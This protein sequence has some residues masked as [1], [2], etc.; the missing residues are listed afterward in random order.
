MSTNDAY[1]QR[2][3]PAREDMIVTK[4]GAHFHGR[5][6]ACAIGRGGIN[7]KKTEGDGVSPRGFWRITN[8]RFRPD[9]E[10]RPTTNYIKFTP[11]LP[12]DIWSDDIT[13]PC[14]NHGLKAY[15]HPFS[16]E[17]LRRADRLYDVILISDWN[18]PD[19]IASK[20]SAIFVHKWRKPRHPTEGCIAFAAPD[21]KWIIAHW[22][23][24][25]RILVR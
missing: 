1:P 17:R 10:T 23:P 24:R 25:S 8:G 14:Y 11:V 13:D 21:L 5:R 2:N 22:S 16:H 18:F 4:W 19:A 12:F 15:A 7:A 6:F 3:I 9:R 20:G